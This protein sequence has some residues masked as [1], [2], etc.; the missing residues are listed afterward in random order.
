[1]IRGLVDLSLRAPVIVVV[2]A[3]MLLSY[4]LYVAAN[5]KLDVFPDF[6]PPEVTIQTEAPGLSADQVEALVTRPVET[7]VNGVGGLEAMRS[8]S[9]QGLSIITVVFKESTDVLAAR[10]M[11]AEKIAEIASAL[12]VGVS[13]PRMTPLTSATMDLLKIG[14]T[15]DRMTPMELRSF[16]DWTLRPRLLAVPGVA[17]ASVFGGEVRQIQIQIRPERLVA[18]DVSLDE[19]RA[20]SRAST[21]V[22]G[23]GF[24]ETDAQRIVVE[25]EGQSLTPVEIGDVVVAVR[26]GHPVRIADLADV[27]EA[28]EPKQGDT[29]VMGRPGILVTMSSQYG[30]NTSEVTEL[31]EKAI[32]EMRPV[33]AAEGITLYDRLHRPATFIEHAIKNVKRSLLL[34][35]VFVA[36]VLFLFLL[37]LRTA[38]IS[39]T[40]IPLSLLTAV[41]VMDAF[42]I[43]LN[44]ITL[45]GLAIAIG[46]VVDDAIIDVENIYRRLRET[47][48]GAS[49]R[50]IV[51]DA[52]LEVRTAVVYAT[53]VVVLVFVPVL[54]L[55]GLQGRLF[56]PLGIAYI[57]AILASLGVALTVTP[58]LSLLL[59]RRSAGKEAEPGF[60]RHLKAAYRRILGATLPRPA[61]V[62]AA[63]LVVFAGAALLVPFF[64]GEFIPQFREGHFVLQVF[65]APGTSLPEL[66]RIGTQISKELLANPRI[67]TAEQQVGRAELGEDPWGPHRSEFH[68]EL[69]PGLAPAEE[70]QTEEEIREI[71]GRFP[72][73]TFEVLTFL[74]DRIGETITGEVAEVVVSVFGDDLDAI[75]GK[76]REVAAVMQSTRG[77]VDVQAGAPPSAPQLSVALRKD[78]LLSMGFRPV[79]VLDAVQ[80]AYQ[81]EVVAQTYEQNKVSNVVVI[82]DPALRQD[83]EAV[84]TLLLRSDSGVRVPLSQLADVTSTT[85][86]YMLMHDGARRRQTVTCNVRG[87]DVESFVK[88]LKSR[89]ASTVKMSGDLY[90]AFGGE[91]EVRAQARRELLLHSSVAAVGIVL[92]LSIVLST[93]RN[94]LLVLA[95]LPFA[96]VGGVLAVFLTSGAV[97]SALGGG[98]LRQGFSA[99]D[100]SMGS[101]IGFVTLFGITT[102]NSIM[103]ISHYEH[104]VTTEGVPWGRD[105]VLRGASERVVP[106]LMTAIV[107][108]LGLLPIALGSGKAGGEIEGPMA[109]VILGGLAT[110]TVL[111]LLVLPTLALRFGRFAPHED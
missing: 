35:G 66:I 73:I 100:L 70:V 26:Q 63:V 74:G 38:F 78:R 111:N 39:I 103:L 64:G 9:I 79:Q 3:A 83:P 105:A 72:G 104:L 34:G 18:F 17:K 91:A 43:S 8:Q 76:A 55:S 92:L 21:G 99:G 14:L 50:R 11:L 36:I 101:L 37:N 46:E 42:H 85:G 102:R 60:L 41:V 31:L 61:A 6:V 98:F 108:A 71:L 23:G 28:A 7:A 33:F 97:L 86:R 47:R 89:V 81:G 15:S 1:M 67:A 32:A 16:A 82:L 20:A 44:T 22:R 12:P 57:L 59:L 87:R 58:A 88:E 53:F 5:A 54:T 19:L 4:G 84:E 65:A 45:G 80:T 25:I 106:I 68:V 94:L 110:S 30:A 77:A 40:A 51:L 52:S 95:N 107:T 10:Q 62:I 29:V 13:P 93:G 75:E 109:I 69:K 24:V 56:A 96:F 49:A 2:L 27:R 48:T 90:A